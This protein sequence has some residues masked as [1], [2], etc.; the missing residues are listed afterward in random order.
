METSSARME[1]FVR[2]FSAAIRYFPTENNLFR[3]FT[4]AGSEVFNPYT[5]SFRFYCPRIGISWSATGFPERLTRHLLFD[6]HYQI[7][8]IRWIQRLAP[9][10][11][12]VFDVGAHHG[13]MSVIAGKAVGPRGKVIAFE[14]HPRSRE[15][16]SLHAK[17]N[18]LHNISIEPVGAMDVAQE[19][20]FY[21][22]STHDSWNSSFI[23]E[24][25]EQGEEIEPIIVPCTTVDDYVASSGLTPDLVKIDTEGTELRVIQGALKTIESVRPSLILELNPRSASAAGTTIGELV[26]NLSSIGYSFWAFPVK[27]YGGYRFDPV[28]YHEGIRGADGD[29]VNVAC[30][31]EH[32]LGG[33]GGRLKLAGSR[34]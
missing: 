6:G 27:R 18:D 32:R 5:F 10:S 8:V 22:Q 21:P 14:P 31:P 25:V 24:F 11:G 20:R 19:L 9:K 26:S 34:S 17:L 2:G 13:L 7:D 4:V 1:K 30:I 12:T 23:R 16:L 15:F 29:L 28:P 3:K 33:L